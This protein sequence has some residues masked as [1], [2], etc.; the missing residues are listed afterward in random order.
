M[1]KLSRVLADWKPADDLCARDPVV[2][3]EAGWN[4]IVGPEVA[5]N[6]RP[7]RISGGTLTI[8]TRSS[9][10]SHQLIFLSEH[11]LRAIAARVS[12][13]GVERLRFRVGRLAE[14][15]NVAPARR[16]RGPSKNAPERPDSASTAEAFARL[17]GD[18]ERA[19]NDRRAHGWKE[20]GRCGA[21]VT[22]DAAE[23]CAACAAAW[24]D[25]L[26]AATARLLFEAPWL[27]YAGTAALVNGLKEEEYERL[28]TRMLSHWWGVL[29]RARAT[30]RLSRDDRERL[31]ASSYV[32]LRSKLP[33]EEIEPVTVRSILGDELM[34]LLYGA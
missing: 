2:L 13:A 22:L 18:M 21:L 3:L 12:E 23:L 14:R 24:A 30:K 19:A 10:W 29:L 17:K 16:R 8:L 31:V 11:V 1:L 15:P 20:C 9:A 34:E 32:L 26:A 27:G 4:E 33:P 7:L 6:S 25:E 5:Q 28:R